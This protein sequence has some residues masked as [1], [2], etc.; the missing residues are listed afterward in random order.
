[1]SKALP[2][3][4]HDLRMRECQ[5]DLDNSARLDHLCE[6][7]IK[8]MRADECEMAWTIEAVARLGEVT[9]EA[10]DA[11]LATQFFALPPYEGRSEEHT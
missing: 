11:Y 6:Q 5:R 4:S 7:Y 10:I 2:C 1:M 3:V 9:D 8:R